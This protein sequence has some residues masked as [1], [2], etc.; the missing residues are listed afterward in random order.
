VGGGYTVA[1]TKV[2][3]IYQKYIILEFTLPPPFLE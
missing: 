3:T 2:L 1:F